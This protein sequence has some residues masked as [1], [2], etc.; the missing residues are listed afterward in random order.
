MMTSSNGN[1]FRNN[2]SGTETGIFREK[3]VNTV[4]TD[5]LCRQDNSSRMVLAMQD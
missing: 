2:K 5:A 4:A 3:L 1:I